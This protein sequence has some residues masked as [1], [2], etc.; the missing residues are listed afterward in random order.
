ME[1]PK[2]F[3]K[4]VNSAYDLFMRLL[5]DK[6]IEEYFHEKIFYNKSTKEEYSVSKIEKSLDHLE[7][8]IVINNLK[9][10]KSKRIKLKELDNLYEIIIEKEDKTTP[11]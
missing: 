9:T 8:I 3:N 7:P 5:N 1:T 2:A 11:E 10:N 6:L 4:P